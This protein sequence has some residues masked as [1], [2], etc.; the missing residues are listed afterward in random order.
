M[1]TYSLPYGHTKLSIALPDTLDVTVLEPTPV[2]ATADPI[3]ILQTALDTP[4]GEVALS[5]L[6]HAAGGEYQVAIALNDKTRPVPHHLILPPLL[7]HLAALGVPATAITL[8]IAT[9]THIPTPAEE[10]SQVVPPDVL[11]RHR[12]ISHDCD[13]DDLVNCGTTSRGTPVWLNRAFAEADVRI[14]VG[15]IEP[16]HF[17]GFSGGVK[18][19]AIGLAGRA[20]ATAN[21]R[22]LTDARATLARYDDNPLRQDIE[23]I[24]RLVDVHFAFNVVMNRHKK[25]VA[26]FAGHPLSVMQ[27]AIPFVRRIYEVP[28]AKPFDVLITS[29]GGYPK[30]I[31]L[32][33]AH[34]A[35]TPAFYVTR[36]G[37]ALILLAACEEGIGHVH[38]AR[39]MKKHAFTSHD[40]V[41]ETFKREPFQ[42]GP[43]KAFLFA[44]Q[45]SQLQGLWVVSEIVPDDVKRLLLNPA[46][47]EQALAA[48]I[49]TLPEGARVG[50]IPYANATIPVLSAD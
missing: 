45:A 50:I 24:G 2:P 35:V 22:Y 21:H 44:R 47:V 49:A 27:A 1:Q 32:Y 6:I 34:K 41:L 36:K 31:N 10:F 37:G 7:Q 26:A 43:H 48:T 30:D 46:T 18:S 20:T 33:Q 4:L 5:N 11:A 19:A 16:H 9:G 14:V 3:T 12:V 38:Y 40:A 28:V 13:V 25:I 17:A 39:W 15:N 23:D 29:P 42:L 8:I